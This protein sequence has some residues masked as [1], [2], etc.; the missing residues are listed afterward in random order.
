MFIYVKKKNKLGKYF[1]V[2]IKLM[3]NQDFL[4]YYLIK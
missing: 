1:G 3:Y 2:L 4:N